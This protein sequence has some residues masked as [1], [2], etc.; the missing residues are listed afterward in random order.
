MKASMMILVV[1]PVMTSMMP[2]VET[3]VMPAM[4]VGFVTNFL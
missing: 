3:P 2:S 4:M 1:T